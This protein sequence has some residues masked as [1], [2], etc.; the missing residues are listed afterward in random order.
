MNKAEPMVSVIMGVRNGGAELS[1]AV[2][3]ILAQTVHEFEFV[4]CD[5]GSTDDTRDQLERYAAKDSRL[6]VIHA[7]E[8]KGLAPALNQ[9]LRLARGQYIARMDA[10]DLSD[11]QR[12]EQQIAYLEQ[13]PEVAFVGCCTRLQRLGA[14]V[15]VRAFP[16]FPT[17][18][19]FYI[20]QPFLHPTLMFRREALAAVG[21]YCEDRHC[22]LCEDYDLLLRL[23]TKGFHGANLQEALFT[24]TLPPTARG[25]R[26]MCHRWNEVVTR[27]RR[28]RELKVLPGALL[29]VIKPVIVGLLP[30]HILSAI[31]STH[32]GEVDANG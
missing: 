5:D 22:V 6:R 9:C 13:H 7:S 31:K 15:G 17:I 18:R 19:D 28:F 27:W 21:G 4:I 3:S 32:A 30:E 14:I 26:K 24:Y 20:A 29:W 8:N 16:E 23:Y 25:N 10:D 11:P 1:P 2:N 12:L